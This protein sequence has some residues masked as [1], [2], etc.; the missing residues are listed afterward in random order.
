MLVFIK[1][2]NWAA[3]SCIQT[4]SKA[5]SVIYR[6]T[7]CGRAACAR[8]APFTASA[9]AQYPSE[10]AHSV[11]QEA[12][13]SSLVFTQAMDNYLLFLLFLCSQPRFQTNVDQAEIARGRYTN[14]RSDWRSEAVSQGSNRLEWLGDFRLS[15]PL[16]PHHPAAHPPSS[17][18]GR[19]TLWNCGGY[20]RAAPWFSSSW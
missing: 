2:E 17:A 4:S 1:V 16:S 13:T 8:V 10:L 12:A 6:Q 15:H 18:R 20:I 14:G 7:F 9:E 11:P 5:G 19:L 3:L